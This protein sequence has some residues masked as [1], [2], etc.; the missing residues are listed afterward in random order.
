MAATTTDRNTLV[1]DGT[2]FEDPVAASANIHSGAIVCL[3]AS[4]NAVPASTSTGLTARGRAE[5][6]RD[7]T[8]G[9]AGS[10]TVPVR[11]GVFRYGNDGTIDRTHIGKTV[12]LVDDQTLAATDGTGTRSAAGVCK[13]VDAVGVWVLIG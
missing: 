1:R 4:G 6:A 11:A 9:L 3:D 13:D 12:Y 10:L 7:N 2:T 5:E 8:S